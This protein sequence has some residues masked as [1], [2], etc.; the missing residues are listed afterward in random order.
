VPEPIE[1]R[2]RRA[3]VRYTDSRQPEGPLAPFA[4][5]LHKAQRRRWGRAGFASFIAAVAAIGGAV[6]IQ[7]LAASGDGNEKVVYHVDGPAEQR[8]LVDGQTA[9]LQT[10]LDP[11]QIKDV[12]VDPADPKTLIVHAGFNTPGM[13]TCDPYTAVRILAQDA[14]TVTIAAYQY[15]WASPPPT[16]DARGGGAQTIRLSLGAPLGDRSVVEE[17]GTKPMDVLDPKTLLRPRY[18]PAG[19]DTV[20]SL[21]GGSSGGGRPIWRFEGP[22]GAYLLVTVPGPAM[23]ASS[24]IPARDDPPQRV[25]TCDVV[26][27]PMVRDH[28]ATV[29]SGGLTPQVWLRWS[30]VPGVGGSGYGEV[31]TFGEP[32]LSVAE[33]VKVAQSVR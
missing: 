8:M 14:S 4:E 27:H 17:G 12:I 30:E 5:V 20:G 6:A 11:G 25:A 29:C 33:V 24:P 9:V 22:G 10:K 28:R 16:C 13:L 19:Y 1:S 32:Q 15:Q 21:T 26:E 18:L 2:L 3:L 23:L 31:Q 7:T